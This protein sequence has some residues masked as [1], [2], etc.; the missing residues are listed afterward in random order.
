MADS[1][2]VPIAI[3]ASTAATPMVMPPMVSDVCSRLRR[4]ARKAMAKLERVGT[5]F[6]PAATLTSAKYLAIALMSWSCRA[7]GVG[8]KGFPYQPYEP[9]PAYRPCVPPT[10]GPIPGRPERDGRELR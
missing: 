9:Y 7:G 10:L 5:W 8:G 2:P 4:S 6:L 3:I 1:A